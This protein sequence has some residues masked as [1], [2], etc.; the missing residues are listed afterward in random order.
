[1]KYS[2][3]TEMVEG[4]LIDIENDIMDW[5]FDGEMD[6]HQLD[7]IKSEVEQIKSLL[8]RRYPLKA[9]K[10][11]KEIESF[12]YNCRKHY[13]YNYFDELQRDSYYAY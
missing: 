6:Q 5:E 12:I 1:M 2:N 10:K 9:K 7:K 4:F 13:S 8:R 3:E 11:V